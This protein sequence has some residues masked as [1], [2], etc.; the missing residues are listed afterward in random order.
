MKTDIRLI[1]K[2]VNLESY[3]SSPGFLGYF[4]RV[5]QFN[6]Q[7]CHNAINIFFEAFKPLNCRYDLASSL[8]VDS[9]LSAL[10]E[11]Y[12]IPDDYFV[13]YIEPLIDAGAINVVNHEDLKSKYEWDEYIKKTDSLDKH[14]VV[15][16]NQ[17]KELLKKIFF[18]VMFID[19]IKGHCFAIIENKELIVY[20]HEDIGFGFVS[21]GKNKVSIKHYI[22]EAFNSKMFNLNLK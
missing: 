7:I 15:L 2:F 20:P 6:E 18:S 5:G 12:N 17:N 9:N 8:Y 14:F 1:Q 3:S 21:F 11:E 4:E 19:G 16:N 13:V 22:K 10:R